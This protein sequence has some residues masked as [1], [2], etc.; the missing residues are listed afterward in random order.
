M[1]EKVLRCAIYIRVSTAEQAM[2]GKSLGAQLDFLT[3]YAEEHGMKVVGVFADEGKSAR[4]NFKYRKEIKRLLQSVE[5]DEI[6]VILFWKLDR[7]FRN[8]ADFYK[9]QDILDAH[10]TKWI[11]VAEPNLSMDTRDGRLQLN[12][13]LSIGQNETDT[14]SERIKFVNEAS[15]RQGKVVFGTQSMPFGYTVGMIDGQKRMVK[16]PEKEHIVNDTI[17]YF[18]THQSKCGTVK[19][20]N[21]KYGPVMSMTKLHHVLT[22]TLMYGCF[23]D[24]YNYCPGYMTQDE[25]ERIQQ[26][27]KKNIKIYESRSKDINVYLFPGLIRCPLCGKTLHS[28][29]V[30]KMTRG[31]AKIYRYYRCAIHYTNKNCDYT[32]T[33]SEETTEKYLLQ[34]IMLE[35]EEY[36]ISANKVV[37]EERHEKRLDKTK[38]QKE[39]DRLNTMFQKGRIS[40]EKYDVEYELLQKQLSECMVQPLPVRQDFSRIEEVLHEGWRD[41]YSEL[42][43]EHKRAFWRSIIDELIASP[44]RGCIIG[45]KFL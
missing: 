3:A 19:Y 33:V 15:I 35:L 12:M 39:I 43:K 5:R 26:A 28:Y 37:Q 40:E 24:N 38:I 32:K 7:W 16:D 1:N 41:I 8:V 34:N 29:S 9:V 23:R 45:V 2:H 20:I 6:D 27:L 30:K 36:K 17:Q 10:G 22:S 13:Y 14:T 4:K 44:D 25:Y 21:A 31:K 18:L 11:A 42:D